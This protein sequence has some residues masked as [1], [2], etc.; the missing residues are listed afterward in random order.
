M[1]CLSLSGC[2][3]AILQSWASYHTSSERG[4]SELPADQ[5]FFEFLSIN[6]YF[7]AYF[8]AVPTSAKLTHI[9]VSHSVFSCQILGYYTPI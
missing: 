7:Q 3:L 5:K 6:S 4:E 2:P 9:L 1:K 8:L